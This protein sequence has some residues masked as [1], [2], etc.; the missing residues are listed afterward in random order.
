MSIRKKAI[1][2]AQAAVLVSS[3]ASGAE[4]KLAVM[5]S[6]TGP[7]AFIGAPVKNGMELAV[8]EANKKQLLGVGNTINL[9]IADDGS[10]RSQGLTLAGKFGGDPSILA[11]VGPTT[12]T[13]SPT[14]SAAANDMRL[15]ITPINSSDA[16]VATGPWTFILTQPTALNI[17]Y[18]GAYV[19]EKAKAKSCAIIGV[20]DNITYVNLQDGFKAYMQSHSVKIASVDTVKLSD[21]DFSPIVTKITSLPIDCVFVSAPAAQSANI[22]LQLKRAGLEPD[23]RIFGHTSMAS[24][25]IIEKGGAA[26]EGVHFIA[27]WVPGGSNE[28][29]R[30]FAENYT[31]TYG[32][33]PDNWAA[34]GYTGMTVVIEALKAAGPKPTRESLRDAIAATKDVKVVVGNGSFSIDANRI[35]HYAMNVLAIKS[36]KFVLATD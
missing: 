11:I 36:G 26:V 30:A 24:P 5:Q 28:E 16:T 3:A 32:I 23:V 27:D 29:G 25:D 35:P 34:V 15:P 9:V 12:G 13:V 8:N 22:I 2:A 6:L 4:F 7:A 21:T 31:K 33:A 10:D 14:V 20:S 1:F 17:P 19:V 18:L